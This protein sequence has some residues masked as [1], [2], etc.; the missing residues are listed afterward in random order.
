MDSIKDRSRGYRRF[1]ENVNCVKKT[2]TVKPYAV[3]K[4]NTQRRVRRKPSTKS[5]DFTNYRI[6]FLHSDKD[7]IKSVNKLVLYICANCSIVTVKSFLN[8][9]LQTR[10]GNNSWVVIIKTQPN[11][12]MLKNTVSLCIKDT[13]IVVLD[14]NINIVRYLDYDC[15]FKFSEIA[16]LSDGWEEELLEHAKKGN[17][18]RLLDVNLDT[19]GMCPSLD[20]YD[21]EID[22]IDSRERVR[23]GNTVY[24]NRVWSLRQFSLFNSDDV[25]KMVTV[26]EPGLYFSGKIEDLDKLDLHLIKNKTYLFSSLRLTLC[27]GDDLIPITSNIYTHNLET[28]FWSVQ[29]DKRLRSNYVVKIKQCNHLK[30]YIDYAYVLNLKRRPDRL[31]NVQKVFDTVGIKPKVLEAVDGWVKP[32]V[33]EYKDFEKLPMTARELS[34][35][36]KG[37]NSAGAWGYLHT[38]IKCLQDVLEKIKD[39]EYVVIFDD[40]VMVHKGWLQMFSSMI[41]RVQPFSVLQLGSSQWKWDSVSVVGSWYKPNTYSSGSF[42]NIYNSS[43]IKKLLEETKKFYSNFDNAP[44]KSIYRHNSYVCYPNIFI[45]NL[46][47]SDIRENLNKYSTYRWSPEKYI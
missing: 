41:I 37:I 47:D 19:I 17:D 5:L 38:M 27:K 7:Q 29:V 4:T 23:F 36:Y 2:R 25:Y 9:F 6:N 15:C 39:N 34:L 44:L 43:I 24:V 18:K 10:S 28:G 42:A 32:I 40:D 22:T 31:E 16:V 1:V 3:K 12:I 45:S 35:G 26:V 14:A 30:E 11:D 20:F 33:Y 46:D 21:A 13:P 8:N